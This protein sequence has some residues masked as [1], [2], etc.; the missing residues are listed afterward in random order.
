M[1]ASKHHWDLDRC[2]T[3]R[4]SRGFDH[5]LCKYVVQPL[6]SVLSSAKT[7][8]VAQ[9]S[10][11][12]PQEESVCLSSGCVVAAAEL[13]QHMSPR[14]ED[15]DPCTDFN[16][17][18]CEGW[19]DKHDMR[20]DQEHLSTAALMSENAQ[21][22][23]RHVIES[24][25][26]KSSETAVTM[27]ND[28]QVIFDKLRDGYNACMS[29]T[30][31]KEKASGP[32]IEVLK[33]LEKLYPGLYLGNQAYHDATS[34]EQSALGG[35]PDE[36][37]AVVNYLTNIGVQTILSMYVGADDRDPDTNVIFL[38]APR[39]PGL[40]SREYYKDK[41]VVE[42]YGKV[43]GQVLEGLVHEA[44]PNMTL[45]ETENGWFSTVSGEIVQNVI[46]FET[47]LAK[48]TP[49]T[50]DAEDVTKSYNPK[51]IIEVQF[52]LPQIS[53]P[54]LLSK[55]APS[56]FTPEKLI[57]GSPDY[58]K[59]L[60]TAIQDTSPETIK[61]YLVWKVVQTFAYRVESVAVKPLIEFNN[62]LQGKDPQATE[63]RWRFCVRDANRG[64]GWILSKFFVEKA[65]SK[66][67]KRFGDTIVS[68]IK[69]EFISKLDSADWMSPEVR[70]LG[71]EKVH[72]IVQKI[73]YPT[74][75]PDV[76]NST[77]I[78][79]YYSPVTIEPDTFFQN[80]LSINRFSNR[81]MWS[82]LGKP[83]DRD[84]WGMTASTVNAY[85]N[86]AGNEIVF[87][88]GIMQAPVFYD[89]SIP[90][91][92]SY[93][94]FGSVSGHE[95]S[96]AFDST[97]RHYDE[98]GNYTE[99]WDTETIKSFEKKAQCFIDQ[100]HNFT[101]PSGPDGETPLHVN[102]RLTLGENIA[103]AGG[104]S[105]AFQAWKRREE[106][107]P[108]EKLPGLERF[109]K[110]QMFFISYSNWWCSKIRKEA[111]VNRVYRDPHAPELARILVC[112]LLWGF[113]CRGP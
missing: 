36:L 30:L 20:A 84:E 72:N 17:Y 82:S 14:Y 65:F 52:L 96:H 80:W 98:T 43:I 35:R 46:D 27:T 100:Y 91:Y 3:L 61:V 101:V 37:T 42:S 2:S 10:K 40:P 68:D 12:A 89:P 6:L 50:E 21:Q 53:I 8:A 93:G 78:R 11:N 107:D 110:E 62:I 106:E 55:Q 44:Y 69:D 74:K 81:E 32:L 113:S 41:E 16:T 58:L 95:L 85:Y 60:S 112:T 64:L 66:E 92:L 67:A 94:A 18:V 15:I 38:N 7:Q 102:G 47:K 56:D 79:E 104:L 86:P 45:M 77:A 28:D 99:W 54:L 22:I 71:I 108:D 39:S 24:H 73:G 1:A 90:Q 70:E 31:L 87:P 76:R 26:E 5:I 83:V 103:D 23:L 19:D 13:L 33:H 49:S 75:S 57:I 29:E 34:S 9:S 25:Y 59:G 109:S 105:A 51:S 97:G 63:E 88:A 48:V 4:R 111:A